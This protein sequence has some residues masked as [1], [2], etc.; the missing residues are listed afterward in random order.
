M[1]IEYL[2]E[3]GGHPGLRI[4]GLVGSSKVFQIAKRTM[5]ASVD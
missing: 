5:S 4:I 3:L 1:C 2:G